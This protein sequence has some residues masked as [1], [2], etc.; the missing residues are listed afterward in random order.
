M[1]QK[2]HL[3]ADCCDGGGDDDRL[4]SF[5]P[6][7]IEKKIN[8]KFQ[9]QNDKNNQINWRMLRWDNKKTRK[10]ACT[11]WYKRIQ[12]TK[13]TNDLIDE[14][15]LETQTAS[16]RKKGRGKKRSRNAI[17]EKRASSSS[18]IRRWCWPG[19]DFISPGK[20]KCTG[21]KMKEKWRSK[22]F[23]FE[24]GNGSG[25]LDFCKVDGCIRS[26]LNF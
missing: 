20:G 25:K 16:Q 10:A 26:S 13:L 23:F 14:W 9:Q 19:W 22:G 5:W 21:A 12:V 15:K 7:K 1:W 4:H 8:G 3:S 6:E 11:S 2:T 18:V 17:I 24:W